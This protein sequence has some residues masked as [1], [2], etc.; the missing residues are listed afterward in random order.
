MIKQSGFYKAHL[1]E[2]PPPSP[3]P[4]YYVDLE[5]SVTN[6]EHNQYELSDNMYYVTFMMANLNNFCVTHYPD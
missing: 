5:R 4:D 6:I 2:V 1:P 3:R